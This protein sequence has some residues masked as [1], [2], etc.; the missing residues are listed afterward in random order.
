MC[1][2]AVNAIVLNHPTP[3][4]L[5]YPIVQNVWNPVSCR[6]FF[7]RPCHQDQDTS[8]K[9]VWRRFLRSNCYLTQ[10]AN[11]TLNERL[12]STSACERHS[13]SLKSWVPFL[14]RFHKFEW[15]GA[16]C[17]RQPPPYSLSRKFRPKKKFPLSSWRG[18]LDRWAIDV[19]DL[20]IASSQIGLTSAPEWGRLRSGRSSTALSSREEAIP[21]LDL[22][23]AAHAWSPRTSPL[24]WAFSSHGKNS[25]LHSNGKFLPQYPN[26]TQLGLNWRYK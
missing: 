9:A 2:G 14:I 20:L 26:T 4:Q 8:F 13:R 19:F 11:I 24:R 12:Q 6:K 25:L 18:S 5:F 17:N 21:W 16:L 23:T 15:T 22:D 10:A 7:R 3:L 1:A